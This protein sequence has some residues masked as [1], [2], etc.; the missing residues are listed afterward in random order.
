MGELKRLFRPEFLNRVDE[1]V[2]FKSLT[3]E[4]LRGIVDLMVAELRDRLIAQGMSIE[5]TDAARD[6][7]A[8]EGAD[9]V[10]GARPL[11][12]AIQ[13][14]I[15]DPLSEQLLQGG[16]EAGDIVKVRAKDGKLVFD[17]EKGPIPEPRRRE[18]MA[19]PSFR[20]GPASPSSPA[21]GGAAGGGLAASGE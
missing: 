1:I 12:R 13:T 20:L 2:V 15:E 17:K 5:L 18:S 10:Y 3:P 9:P 21:S 7:V 8:K 6:I 19:R 11:R 4:Q 16:W 14:L